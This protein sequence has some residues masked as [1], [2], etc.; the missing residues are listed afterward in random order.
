MDRFA[1]LTARIEAEYPL[2][3]TPPCP[4]CGEIE[5]FLGK[6]SVRATSMTGRVCYLCGHTWENR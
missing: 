1:E 3:I 2:P 6:T 4:R 5:L